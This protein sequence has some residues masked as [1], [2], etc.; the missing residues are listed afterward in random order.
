MLSTKDEWPGIEADRIKKVWS[1]VKDTD[2]IDEMSRENAKVLIESV[3]ERAIDVAYAETGS[4]FDQVVLDSVRDSISECVLQSVDRRF[5]DRKTYDFVGWYCA[6]KVKIAHLP[7]TLRRHKR[8]H[9]ARIR[10]R[11]TL[12]KKMKNID[13]MV[14]GLG[15]GTISMTVNRSPVMTFIYFSIC[16][17]YVSP[18]SSS[19][20]TQ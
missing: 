14:S 2:R 16:T 9:E 7:E 3:T 11:E 6:I 12:K 10:A 1:E 4:S 19:L 20:S 5:N 18:P 17:S 8:K 15:N 13:R